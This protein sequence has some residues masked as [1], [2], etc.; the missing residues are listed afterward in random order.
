[1]FTDLTSKSYSNLLSQDVNLYKAHRR[2][3]KDMIG[4]GL[5]GGAA[6]A[7]APSDFMQMNPGAPPPYARD[8]GPPPA[9]EPPSSLKYGPSMPFFP[10]EKHGFVKVPNKP[11]PVRANF[12]GPGTQLIK[13]LKRGDK[14]VSEVDRISLKHD[15]D[16]TLAGGKPVPGETPRQRDQRADAEVRAADKE[17]VASIERAEQMGLDNRLNLWP[18]KKAI[19]TKMKLEDMGMSKRKFTTPGFVNPDSEDGKIATQALRNLQAGKGKLK[20]KL[21]TLENPNDP[22][23][24]EA[25]ENIA[26]HQEHMRGEGWKDE[27]KKLGKQALRY[28]RKKAASFLQERKGQALTHI[29]NK[30][31]ELNRKHGNFVSD[32]AFQTGERHLGA[33]ADRAIGQVHGQG[34]QDEFKKFG[35]EALNYGRKKAASFLQERKGQALAA[36][37][38]KAR[39]L[40]K[41]HGNFISDDAFDYG[42]RQAGNLANRALKKLGGAGMSLDAYRLAKKGSGLRLAG[43]GINL[44]GGGLNL[45]GSGL[46]LAGAGRSKRLEKDLAGYGRCI[47]GFGKAFAHSLPKLM[48]GVARAMF[49]GRGKYCPGELYGGNFF[50]KIGAALKSTWEKAKNW[51]KKDLAPKALQWAKDKIKELA[52]KYVPM[53]REQ[54]IPIV[55]EKL[56]D[57]VIMLLGKLPVPGLLPALH[58]LRP[59]LVQLSKMLLEEL[60]KKGEKMVRNSDWYKSID[61]TKLSNNAKKITADAV[62]SDPQVGAELQ[63]HVEHMNS[64][65]EEQ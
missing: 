6:L 13:R 25:P 32:D 45:A 53:I 57:A 39:E 48:S 33:L 11:L 26:Q 1:M 51:V 58:A 63:K 36:L 41:K 50:K 43:A 8:E 40:S 15:I 4:A 62:R 2:S 3:A 49:K 37:S 18:A 7:A 17:M 60:W 16:Y 42:E 29:A 23:H 22:P 30:A 14:P 34:W 5:R 46:K 54:G 47:E 9:R 64:P 19:Q 65:V 31:R 52:A 55:A 35:A 21:G 61:G 24:M 59:A 27:A 44:S 20:R 12:M 10:H 38:K 28:G 56:T